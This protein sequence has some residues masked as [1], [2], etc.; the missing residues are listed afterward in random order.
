MDYFSR[1]YQGLSYAINFL[2]SQN[3]T[4]IDT[5]IQEERDAQSRSVVDYNSSVVHLDEL[6]N[7]PHYEN[8]MQMLSLS[9]SEVQRRDTDREQRKIDHPGDQGPIRDRC[10]QDADETRE[11]HI[12]EHDVH[13]GHRRCADE[14]E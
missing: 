9:A 11:Q 8:R 5:S 10:W 1:K 2:R 3:K 4:N 12:L 14:I 6:S 7:P 13:A